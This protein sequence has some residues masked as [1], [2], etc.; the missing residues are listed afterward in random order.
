M[1]RNIFILISAAS[2]F[3]LALAGAQIAD[4]VSPDAVEKIDA[5]LRDMLDGAGENRI[6]V[7]VMLKGTESMDFSGFEVKY[8]YQLIPG[9]AGVASSTAIREMAESE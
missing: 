3:L 7:I 6:P 9:Q 1:D 8:S 4:A 2:A 5:D